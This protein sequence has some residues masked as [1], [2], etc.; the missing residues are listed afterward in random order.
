MDLVSHVAVRARNSNLLF[1]TCYDS[2]TFEKL[3]GL[4]GKTVELQ[5]NSA[6][7]VLSSESSGSKK[8]D[9]VKTVAPSKAKMARAKPTLQ[10]LRLKN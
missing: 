10:P 8:A 5:I 3:R 2:A 7:D 1:A 6:G 9:A 4:K